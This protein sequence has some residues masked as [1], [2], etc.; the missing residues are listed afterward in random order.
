[1]NPAG[2]NSVIYNIFEN[3]FHPTS[4]EVSG[5][6]NQFADPKTLETHPNKIAI[7]S[8]S[9]FKRTNFL[10]FFFPCLNTLL[11][12]LLIW[13]VYINMQGDKATL[14]GFYKSPQVVINKALSIY[15][16]IW[17]DWCKR[18]FGALNV[19][20]EDLKGQTGLHT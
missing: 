9:E 7:E 8:L 11:H 12:M 2:Y 17:Y 6:S 14:S 4:D 10:R 5:V 13:S 19:E 3:Q 15:N 1:M 20:Q 16:Q 18:V